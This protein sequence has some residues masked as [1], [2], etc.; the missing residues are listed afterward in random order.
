MIGSPVQMGRRVRLWTRRL[1]AGVCV[2]LLGFQA[3][4]YTSLPFQT[5]LPR[6]Q[7]VQV[8]LNDAGRVQMGALLGPA[9]KTV[10]GVVLAQDSSMIRLQVHR[11]TEAGGQSSQWTGESVDIPRGSIAGFQGR[12]LSKAR[13]WI[14]AGVVLGALV[15]SI[16]VFG[17]DGLGGDDPDEPCIGPTCGPNPSI[18]W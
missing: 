13:S 6:T 15:L 18:R 12:Q 10:E 1:V 5:D 16:T 2:L 17:L 7:R 11:V 8:L 9:V 4:C 3:G 14:L